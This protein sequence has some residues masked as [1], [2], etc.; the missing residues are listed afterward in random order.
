MFEL[1]HQQI[2][3]TAL[4]R[5]SIVHTSKFSPW[6]ISLARVDGKMAIFTL[7]SAHGEKLGCQFF[8]EATCQSETCHFSPSTRA[9]KT[10][11]GDNLLVWNWQL[12]RS[13]YYRTKIATRSTE[14]YTS[15]VRP[16]ATH[17]I[18]KNQEDRR[19]ANFLSRQQAHVLWKVKEYTQEISAV[20]WHGVQCDTK[21][22]TG[23]V[24]VHCSKAETCPKSTI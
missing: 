4:F 18:Q 17:T 12:W 7:T 24:Q 8:N 14:F 20:Q 19:M 21:T 9:N 10:C 22:C 2:V 16:V 3:I 15:R 11:Q 5:Q 6:Q 1:V 13:F 23:E